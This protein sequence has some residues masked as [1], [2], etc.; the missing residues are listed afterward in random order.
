[1]STRDKTSK[2]GA[3]EP[4]IDELLEKLKNVDL[5]DDLEDDAPDMLP[6][7]DIEAG[8]WNETTVDVSESQYKVIKH[9]L[10]MDE[11]VTVKAGPGSGKTFTL[12]AR[13]ARLI[14][15]GEVQP[16]EILVLSMANRSVNALQNSLERLVGCEVA[17]Q[18]EISTFHSFCGSVVDQYALMLDP[19][20]LKRRLLD[21]ESWRRLA[22]FFLQKTV[23]LNG[24]SVGATFSPARFDKLLTE[25][26]NGNLTTSQASQLYGVLAEYLDEVFKYMKTHGMMRYQD[27]VM[28]ALKV[29][30]QSLEGPKE[31]LLHR[32][33]SFKM[34][35][36]DEFQDMYPLLLSVVRAVVEYPTLGYEKRVR[37]NT[38]IA[39]DQ[40][41]G[42]YEFL[43]SSPQSME[44]LHKML[45][46]M[47]VTSL[48]LNESHRCTQDILDT[49][50]S[51][52]LGETDYNGPDHILSM[53]PITRTWKPILLTNFKGDEHSMV[54][55]EIIRLICSLGGLIN[56][57][58]IAIL[59]RTND[60]A[61]KMQN[62]LRNNYGLE[63][64]KISLGNIW[65]HSRAR[66]FRDI[67]SIIS[68]DADASFCLLH[69][70]KKLDTCPGAS[71]RASKVFS[72]AIEEGLAR[73][74][75][76]LEDYVYESLSSE[77]NLHTLFKKHQ[78]SLANIAA[79]M[80]QV[81]HERAIFNKLEEEGTTSYLPI[82]VAECLQRMCALSGIRE[83][84][85]MNGPDILPYR[86]ILL[87]FNESLHYCFENYVAHNEFKERT[88]LD[89]FLQNY[90]QEVPPKHQS[91]VQVLTIHSAKGLEFPVVFILGGFNNTWHTI[92]LGENQVPSSYS[93]LLYVACTRAKDLL[94]ISSQTRPGDLSKN[95][96]NWFTTEVPDLSSD[97]S[98]DCNSI[99]ARS[100]PKLLDSKP[101][102]SLLSRLLS[103]LQRPQPSSQKLQRGKE[104]YDIFLQKRYY[105]SRIPNFQLR[106]S[107]LSSK[108]RRVF[109]RLRP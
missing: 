14:G 59:S 75:T 18:V 52:C 19:G 105:H 98:D 96:R 69:I 64:T 62:L 106:M 78:S 85:N 109:H 34:V 73:E 92:L 9:P 17:S 41:Q 66:L 8:E 79:F 16:H 102:G 45:P 2:D 81:Q 1:M 94:Y 49:A 63:C 99:G 103:D 100:F 40:N 30:D 60:E 68:G 39:G 21:Q 23:R 76:F 27:L 20:M 3:S 55:E 37:K 35:V 107:Y 86:D 87:S 56:P 101:Q 38:V 22:E 4:K 5:D 97:S 61:V 46:Q 65:V 44:Q 13:I 89:Y 57:R 29:M 91:L 104:Y 84:M 71:Q 95:C 80:N 74:H 26:A 6:E 83:Y 28:L 54:A 25:I 47:K 36:V 72:R 7:Q 31:E 43:G 10:N 15:E 12:M 88:F 67:L 70:L 48:P 108:T 32:I 33:A 11:I 58:D 42:I 53:K 51:M 24:H 90:D 50:V 93:R 77:A 82:A